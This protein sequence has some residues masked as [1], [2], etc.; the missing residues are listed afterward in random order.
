MI[1]VYRDL[2]NSLSP[3]HSMIT[4]TIFAKSQTHLPKKLSTRLI[5]SRWM[6]ILDFLQITL[7]HLVEE[8]SHK[9]EVTLRLINFPSSKPIWL[10]RNWI[11][12]VLP[13]I[14][15]NWANKISTV[16]RTKC[17]PLI[18]RWPNYSKKPV[19]LK[20]GDLVPWSD[21]LA[22]ANRIL[23]LPSQQWTK[24][25]HRNGVTW[26]IMGRIR[27][28][29][30]LEDLLIKV[31]RIC[32]RLLI[33]IPWEVKTNWIVQIIN[34]RVRFKEVSLVE[35]NRISLLHLTTQMLALTK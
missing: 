27:L 11:P 3:T 17:R 4:R 22:M 29:V 35:S 7:I 5:N 21:N 26:A 2:I 28:V 15:C 10:S 12:P 30:L 32:R 13:I 9:M 1:R 20:Q 6:V 31:P 23:T 8:D 25:C 34:S 14:W 16:R 24:S 18:R 19:L 33:L